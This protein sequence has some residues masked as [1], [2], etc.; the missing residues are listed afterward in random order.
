MVRISLCLC[1]SLLLVGSVLPMAA[2][3]PGNSTSIAA[4]AA[5]VIVP[6]M[7][8]FSGVLADVN[9]KPLNGVVGVT[10]FLYKDSQGGTPLWME[11]QNLRTDKAGHYMVMLGSTSSQGLPAE[12][13][14]SG[15]ARWL[16]V[17]VQGQVEEPRVLLLS[18]PYA[19]K[20]LD[21]ETV[22]GKPASAFQLTVPSSGKG[23]A[24]APT[25]GL[26]SV[27]AAEQAN[28][29]RCAG[30]GTSCKASFIPKFSSNGGSA[31]EN[32][33]IM[34][35]SG[36][37]INVAGNLTG[38][39][40]Q[41]TGLSTGVFGIATATGGGGSTF[42]LEGLASAPQGFGVYGLNNATSGGVGV[43][44]TDI[45]I[46]GVGVFGEG[47]C[48]SN[49]D[50][51]GIGVLGMIS[52]GSFAPILPPVPTAVLADSTHSPNG[53]GVY[54][55]ASGGS[56]SVAGLFENRV[57]GGKLLRGTYLDAFS[58][59]V[60]SFSVTAN[61]RVQTNSI[62]SNNAA[63]FIK[64]A[65]PASAISLAA[66]EVHNSGSSGEVAFLQQSIN[67]NPNAVVKL[68]LQPTSTSNYL[69]CQQ[70]DGTF[71]CHIDNSGTFHSGSDFAEALPARGIR[72]FYEP[73]DVL[74]VSRDGNSVEKTDEEYSSRIV[75]VYS[76]RPAVLG[77]DKQGETRVDAVDIPVAITGIVP[78]KVSAKNGPIQVGDLLVTSATLGYAMKGSNR[79]RM[80]GAVVGKALESLQAGT[81]VI[82][83]LVTLQ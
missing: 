32:N 73:G 50:A 46:T 80:S 74:V 7:V 61:G 44:G 57:L 15:E 23:K 78:T 9:G 82:H 20:A 52:N 8:N 27:P 83:V 75:G 56:S 38:G 22:G 53:I 59:P 60:E 66:L 81:G 68:V 54:G 10:F 58:N 62:G 21:A 26:G 42:G 71:K 29:L 24:S 3:Q 12:L 69:E 33:S 25:A 48:C 19:L 36:T 13:F 72:K 67:T 41:G 37:N 5:P 28:E 17:Q 1:A 35:Q 14:A 77:S 31:T 39:T 16:G 55:K 6:P 65:S 18:V 79:R 64:D 43:Q 4:T 76:T 63:V 45:N 11:T 51:G 2:Q 30:G 47:G 40:L 70:S 49:L 34:S